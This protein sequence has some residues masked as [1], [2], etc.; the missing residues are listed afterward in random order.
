M[1]LLTD[2]ALYYSIGMGPFMD[3]FLRLCDKDDYPSYGMCKISLDEVANALGYWKGFDCNLK[4]YQRTLHELTNEF[5]VENREFI[6]AQ[7]DDDRITYKFN[8]RFYTKHALLLIALLCDKHRKRNWLDNERLKE[9][10]TNYISQITGCPRPPHQDR[11]PQG[12]DND[13]GSED[14]QSVAD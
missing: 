9:D 13:D 3:Q 11:D 12:L 7:A 2:I 1:N 8:T 5:L 6:T 4:P 14:D 10:H